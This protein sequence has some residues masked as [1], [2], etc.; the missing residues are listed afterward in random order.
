MSN[1]ALIL[2]DIQ[3]DFCAG[4][5]LEVPGGEQIVVPVNQLMQRFDNVIAT[6]DWHP[7]DHFS[8]ADN[9][10]GME[11]F[12]VIE[13]S[14]GSQVLWPRHCVQGSQGAAFHPAL[15]LEPVQAVIRKGFRSTI[16]SY[17]AFFENDHKT[18]T[19][20][21]GYLRARGLEELVMVGLAT[22]FCVAYSAID[23]AKEGFKVKV[24]LEHCRAIDLD[25]SL[26]KAMV[27]MRTAG[28]NIIE[29]L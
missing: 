19:G 4:G 13:A 7:A 22:D 6:Q 2:V 29:G 5:A 15:N 3:N 16:D 23:A 1:T 27:E 28:V 18:A 8:F 10:Q 26:D 9:H 25:G 20:L 12:G 21:T 14:Y 17:S 24:I 11:A